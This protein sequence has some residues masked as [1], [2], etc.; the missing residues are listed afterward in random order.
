MRPYDL[1]TDQYAKYQESIHGI[2]LA[3]GDT[4]VTTCFDCHGGHEILEANDPGSTV[5]PTNVPKLCAGCHSDKQLMA[6]YHIP[7]NQFELYEQSVHGHALIDNQDLRAPSCATCHGTHGAAPPGFEEVANVCGSCHSATQEHYLQSPHAQLGEAGPK[8]VT[9]HGRYDVS[10]PSEAMYLGTEPRHCGSCHSPES[11]GGK[12]AQAMYDAI[13]AATDAYDQ[14]EVSVQ[15]AA[16]LGMVVATEKNQLSDA[17]TASR[18]TLARTV[19]N[20]ISALERWRPSRQNSPTH[21]TCGYI[22]PTATSDLSHRPS[23]ACV[24]W[25]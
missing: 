9:C 2:K 14:A 25:R 15:A 20:A 23:T 3:E 5:Y 11:E 18:H 12:S 8:C 13:T 4:N 10:K 24:R 22:P 21:V 6:P 19:A 7:T 17:N 16:D 1:P